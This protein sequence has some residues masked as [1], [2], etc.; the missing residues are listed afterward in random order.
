MYVSCSSIN[1]IVQNNVFAKTVIHRAHYAPNTKYLNYLATPRHALGLI[2]NCL[3]CSF[4]NGGIS[5]RNLKSKHAIYAI[6]DKVLM[7]IV[8]HTR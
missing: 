1:L 2:S 6:I 7:L 5:I 3:I 8:P 4:V